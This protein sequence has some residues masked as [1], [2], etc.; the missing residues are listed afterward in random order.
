[1]RDTEN[2]TNKDSGHRVGGDEPR[3]SEHEEK[4]TR[5]LRNKTVWIAN[6]ISSTV[7]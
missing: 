3:T 5:N 1:M 2:Y 7:Y 6:E 4:Q